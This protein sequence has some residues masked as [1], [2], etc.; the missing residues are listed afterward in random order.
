MFKIPTGRGVPHTEWGKKSDR[1][2]SNEVTTRTAG[3][4]H[5]T[6]DSSDLVE[7][8]ITRPYCVGPRGEEVPRRGIL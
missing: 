2:V 7:A 8:H 4:R 6:A 1:V 3:G 5:G